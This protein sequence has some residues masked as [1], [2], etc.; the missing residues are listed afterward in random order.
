MQNPLHG[1]ESPRTWRAL[2]E[3]TPWPNPLHGV[4]SW[5]PTPSSPPRCTPRIHYMELKAFQYVIKPWKV[6]NIVNPLHGVESVDLRVTPYDLIV[7]E[8]IT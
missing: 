7:R 4:E 3:R 5:P 2:L 8:S 6:D 1:V